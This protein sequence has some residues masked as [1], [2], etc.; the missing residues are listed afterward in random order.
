MQPARSTNIQQLDIRSELSQRLQ[1][2]AAG[3]LARVKAYYQELGQSSMVNDIDSLLG[4]AS[5]FF[6]DYGITLQDALRGE[7][8]DLPEPRGHRDT[9]GLRVH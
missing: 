5:L 2:D 3:A 8:E 7:R 4:A 6:D 1:Q 9:G